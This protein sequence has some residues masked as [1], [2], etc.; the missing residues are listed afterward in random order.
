MAS[1][2]ENSK[3]SGTAGH[4]NRRTAKT[5][6]QHV[7]RTAEQQKHEGNMA[8]EQQNSKNISTAWHQSRR[9]A[10]HED[11]IAPEHQNSKNIR[12]AWHQNSRTAKTLG[13][14][15]TRAGEQQSMR[16]A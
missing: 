10:K 8:P 11:S 6:G 13:Q 2:Q 9:T 15:G 4:Q 1:E 16:I 5:L 12:A 3:N 14:H 7:T